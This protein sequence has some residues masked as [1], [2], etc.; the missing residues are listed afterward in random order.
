MELVFVHWINCFHREWN[1]KN[2]LSA[3]CCCSRKNQK[4]ILWYIYKHHFTDSDK[5]SHRRNLGS[6]IRQ[7]HPSYSNQLWM[8]VSQTSTIWYSSVLTNSI[9]TQ[10][11]AWTV[12]SRFIAISF[13]NI[14]S[15]RAFHCTTATTNSWTSISESKFHQHRT[16]NP[17][18]TFVYK[19][20]SV[21]YQ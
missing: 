1:I 16:T 4:I 3:F 10:S 20:R 21:K 8:N 14:S 17:R 18:C 13:Q 5:N 9:V 12:S 2:S 19:L 11:A 15:R 7:T 6:K